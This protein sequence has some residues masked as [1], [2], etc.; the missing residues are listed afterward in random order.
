M[1]A[2]KLHKIL[3]K[4]IADGRGSAQVV[5]DKETFT[6]PLNGMVEGCDL[7]PVASHCAMWVPLAGDEGESIYT[8]KGE[9]RG[10]DCVVLFGAHPIGLRN[11]GKRK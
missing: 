8:A 3:T 7:L 11:K 6:H 5:I 2:N 1:T 10:N 4:L 9:E